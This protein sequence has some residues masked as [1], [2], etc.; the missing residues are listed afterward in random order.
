M[1]RQR[2]IR[3]RLVADQRITSLRNPGETE[4]MATV[5]APS[6]A[7]LALGRV[8]AVNGL[9]P[10]QLGRF[11]PARP[12]SKQQRKIVVLLVGGV[13]YRAIA[14]ELDISVRTVKAHVAAIANWI[15]GEDTPKC[16][17]LRCAS[18]LLE[19]E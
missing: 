6:L 14:R 9:T 12:L 15:P 3:R 13:P 5:L 11:T 4:R 17:V 2:R 16:R 19:H 7:G 8:A 10:S 18:M 1:D